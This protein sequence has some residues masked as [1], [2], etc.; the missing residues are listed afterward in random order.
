VPWSGGRYQPL[1]LENVYTANDVWVSK[2][3][4][5]VQEVVVAP[6]SMKALGFCVSINHAEFMADKFNQA[7]VRA[8]AVSSNTNRS[9]RASALEQL[10]AGDLNV[11]FAVD[12]F[13]EGID[14]P[15]VDTILML[16]PTES[17]TIFLQQLGRG[18]RKAEGKTVLTVLDFVGHQRAEFRFDQRFGRLLGRSR[19]Q[20]ERDVET[21]FPFL[22]AGCEINLDPEAQEIVLAN[23]KAAMPATFPKR[24]AELRSLGPLPMG[25]FLAEANLDVT[26]IY[27]GNNYWTSTRRAAGH[28]SSTAS[29]GPGGEKLLGR[30]IRRLLHLDDLPRIDFVRDLISASSMP[31]ASSLSDIEERSVTM[32]LM[33][34]LSPKKGQY[35]SVADA[36]VHVWSFSDIRE[37]LLELL[38]VLSE[39]VT[40]LHQPV[41]IDGVPLQVHATYTR[42]EAI[43]AFGGATIEAPPSNREGVWWSESTQTDVF[44]VTLDKSDKS[45]SP[46]TRYRDYAISDLLF[47]WESQARTPVKSSV[48]QRYVNQRV[49]GTNVA[50]FIRR[51]KQ[52][53]D[54]RTQ[55]YFFAGLADYVSH[56]SEK[57]IQLTWRLREPLPGDIFAAFR[58]AVA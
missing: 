1:A 43:A 18:L 8:K 30:G 7:G 41:G 34:L 9:E 57:P 37:E 20:I 11:L 25:E 10:R 33:T 49:G 46:T 28:L 45:F 50:M 3:L 23:I 14:V 12:L 27:A 21:G 17:A 13:N 39:R 29:D 42:E 38:E 44:F 32:L 53:P 31:D 56:K 5:A 19:R 54:G 16:R 52:T 2:V 55:P 4:A 51:G 35:A 36:L 6:T 47:H 26:D 58:A 48:G 15:D 24:V 40:H 22:P